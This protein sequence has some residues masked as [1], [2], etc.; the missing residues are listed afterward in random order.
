MNPVRIIIHHSATA[1]SKTFS[2]SAIK[3]YHTQ[4]LGWKDIGYHAG[5]EFVDDDY[6]LLFGR[7]WDMDG[8]HTLGQNSKALGFC[9]V[10]NFD[11]WTPE[12]EMLEEGAKVIK[13]WRR[14]YGIPISEVHKHSEYQN[15]TCPGEKFP[16]AQFL[17]LCE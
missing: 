5:I 13:L 11:L 2:W 1:D 8:A 12:L 7:P 16:W 9:F 17:A 14:L 3:R 4:E 10:G 15:K 6:F